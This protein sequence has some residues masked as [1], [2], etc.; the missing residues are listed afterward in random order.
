[1]SQTPKKKT[2][3]ISRSDSV[4]ML[5]ELSHRIKISHYLWP[6]FHWKK[7]DRKNK[8]TKWK[9]GASADVLKGSDVPANRVIGDTD[10]RDANHYNHQ[11]RHAHGDQ[12][13]NRS[14]RLSEQAGR[15]TAKRN[16]CGG[17]EMIDSTRGEELCYSNIRV[18]DCRVGTV[19][20]GRREG[21][22]VH[23]QMRRD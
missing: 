21:A 12:Q 9:Q 17:F 7:K 22:S 16:A 2:F 14:D 23:I 15:Q 4:N 1:M 19:P 11:R 20:T 18:V 10:K 6:V 3:P 13:G 8:A 5:D